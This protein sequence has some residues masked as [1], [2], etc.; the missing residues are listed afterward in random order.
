[1]FVAVGIASATLNRFTIKKDICCLACFGC[2][3]ASWSR[4][5][6]HQ[7]I[8]CFRH[9]NWCSLTTHICLFWARLLV[10]LV[11]FDYALVAWDFYCILSSCP[12]F[13]C[14]S[15]VSVP[16]CSPRWMQKLGWLCGYK[17]TLQKFWKYM[18]GCRLEVLITNCVMSKAVLAI[19]TLAMMNLPMLDFLA[20]CVLYNG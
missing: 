20:I 4:L 17:A 6:D 15:V 16:S 11:A 3:W 19:Q 14:Q 2:W 12:S 9:C 18:S 1:M 5:N 8:W 13:I 10:V 7:C